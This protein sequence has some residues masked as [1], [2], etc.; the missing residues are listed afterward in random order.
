M[1]NV[2]ASVPSNSMHSQIEVATFES[3]NHVPVEQFSAEI[4]MLV[5][6]CL[7][8][9]CMYLALYPTCVR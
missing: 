4:I 5:S 9:R 6:G 7:V 8:Q 3:Q 2:E 1:K